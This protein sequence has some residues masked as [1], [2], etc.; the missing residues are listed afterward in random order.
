MT[1]QNQVKQATEALQMM[2]QELEQTKQTETVA[3]QQVQLLERALAD[4]RVKLDNKQQEL[5]VDT[6]KAQWQ[7]QLNRKRTRSTGVN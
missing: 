4:A 3:T 7:Y 2:Q 1:L 6:Q 5:Q